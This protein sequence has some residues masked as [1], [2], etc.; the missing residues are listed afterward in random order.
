MLCIGALIFT[1]NM[2]VSVFWAIMTGMGTIDRMKKL[3]MR[4]FDQSDEAP[5]PWTHVFG[6]GPYIT[7]LFPS[8]P[9][10]HDYDEI[11]GYSNT[12]RLVR[13]KKMTSSVV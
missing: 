3:E 7:W 11:M 8:D 6:V 2:I 13:E 10:F 1:T 5:I 9:I 4:T 12:Q